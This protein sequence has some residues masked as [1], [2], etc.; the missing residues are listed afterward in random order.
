MTTLRPTNLRT[1]GEWIDFIRETSEHLG[2]EGGARALARMI[3]EEVEMAERLARHRTATAIRDAT[4][5]AI[6]AFIDPHI[7]G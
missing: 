1:E 6:G 2:S 7:R 5:Q 4:G 3:R